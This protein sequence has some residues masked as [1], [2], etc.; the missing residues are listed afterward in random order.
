MFVACPS[1]VSL[2]LSCDNA[3]MVP[4]CL[5]LVTSGLSS[6]KIQL[7]RPEVVTTVTVRLH[8]PRDS[9]TIGLSQLLLLGV[10]AFG[11]TSLVPSASED[12]VSK[13]RYARSTFPSGEA[14]S[15]LSISLPSASVG[16]SFYGTV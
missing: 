15:Q 12:Y 14:L 1:A 10:T 9:Q 11:D 5:P 7:L 13:T 6:V 4:A 16:C 2:E 3:V 8:K